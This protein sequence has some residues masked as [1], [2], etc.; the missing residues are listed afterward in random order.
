MASQRDL[1]VKFLGDS[2]GL[3]QAAKEAISGLD[4]TSTAAERVA[5][6]MS[7]SADKMKADMQATIAATDK[8]AAAL[9]DDMV[10][11]IKKAGGSVDNLI[12]DFQRAGLTIEEIDSDAELLAA[13]VRKVADAGKEMSDQLD[14]SGSRIGD[15]FDTIGDASG[16]ATKRVKDLGDT[17]DNSRSVLANLVGNSAQDLGEL[18]GVAG[19]AGVAI[20]QLAEY[21]V[22]GNIKLG[23]LAKVAGPMALVG[24]AIAAITSRAQELEKIDAFRTDRVKDFTKA[25]MESKSEAEALNDVLSEG[26]NRITFVNTSG[27]VED[28]TGILAEAKITAD[29]FFERMAMPPAEFAIWAGKTFGAGD[30]LNKLLNA[31]TQIREDLAQ[32]E[33]DAAAA[34]FVYGDQAEKTA[35]DTDTLT[36]AID[37]T[38]DAANELNQ[39][40]SD[41]Q[42]RISD[43][44]AILDL[45][46]SLDELKWKLASGE[47]SAREQEQAILDLQ[48]RYAGLVAEAENIP[49]EIRTE[50]A[51]Q[52]DAQAFDVVQSKLDQL[53]RNRV[54]KIGGQFV[55]AGL[56]NDMEGRA[57]GGPV[58]AG[59][60]Y[61]VGER[62]PEIVVPG[63]AGTVIPNDQL[64]GIGSGATNTTI[65]DNRNFYIT[66]PSQTPE[67]LANELARFNR[68]N[69]KN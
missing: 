5:A 35:A 36:S 9:G 30:K 39:A 63:Q 2:K 45:Q 61:L 58:K 53:T 34:S 23:N 20:G 62:G 16:R 25:L 37:E 38:T 69:G 3:V 51:A 12:R 31:G 48:S 50:L 14:I 29:E 64:A 21:A 52:I 54:V 8:L 66:L 28:L 43:R 46:D 26:E 33:L 67:S 65:N 56:R 6:A 40:V 60:P 32:A 24:L 47:L 1:L 49:E 44:S 55:G 4:D 68:R 22:D 27:E 11:E 41:L 19:T 17:S 57:A 42:T 15:E 10:A 7:A 13:A 59:T 18:G